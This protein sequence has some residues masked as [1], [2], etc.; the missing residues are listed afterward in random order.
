VLG[1]P[2]RGEAKEIAAA[3]SEFRA[4]GFDHVEVVLW[5]PTLEALD[6]MGPVLELLE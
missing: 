6:A 3:F 1:V 5:P 4:A 2:I